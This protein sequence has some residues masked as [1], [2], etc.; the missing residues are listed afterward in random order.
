MTDTVQHH[1]SAA[2]P[3]AVAA[4]IDEQMRGTSNPDLN[5]TR[6]PSKAT[7]PTAE[8]AG[9]TKTA[10]ADP[11]DLATT[12][13][14][15]LRPLDPTRRIAVLDAARAALFDPQALALIVAIRD[16]G[17]G[18]LAD[19]DAALALVDHSLSR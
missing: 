2:D 10:K 4:V 14:T 1:I 18:T 6:R 8:W 7:Y 5:R 15:A 11:I 12:L 3:G 19:L 9:K 17:A 16:L 13:R